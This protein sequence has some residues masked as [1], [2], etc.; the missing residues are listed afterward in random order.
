MKIEFVNP[1]KKNLKFTQKKTVNK[2]RKAM[3]HGLAFLVTAFI[4][5]IV[6]YITLPAYNLHSFGFLLF[7]A[8]SLALWATLDQI[9]T[10]SIGKYHKLVYIFSGLIV[11]F[12]AIFS[13][14]SA[15]FLNARAYRDQ[16]V[17]SEISSFKDGFEAVDLN[18]V[19]VLDKE[20]AIQLG[21]KQ[22]GMVASLGSQYFVHDDYTL[23]A[24]KDSIYRISALDYRDAIK[25][26]N[27][28]KTGITSF[29]S[30]NVTNPNDVRLVDYPQG[31]RYTPHAHL[32]DNLMRKVRFNHR[33]AIIGGYE[34]EV[35]DDFNPFWVFSVVKPEIGWFGGHSA[36]GVIILNPSTG[37]SDYYDLDEVPAWVDRVQ[38]TEIAWSQIDNWGYYVNGFINTLF[39]QKE[40]LQTTEGYNYVLLNGNIYVFSGITSIGADNSIVGFALINLKTK[41]AIFYQVGG[42]DEYSAMSSA[43][44]QVQHLNYKATFPVLLNIGNVPSYFMSLKD[45]EGLVKKYAFVSVSNYDA[46]G[47]GDS[48]GAALNDYGLRLIDF[49]IIIEDAKLMDTITGTVASINTIVDQ[50][51]TIYYI[52]LNE[53]PRLFKVMAKDNIE[54][55][56]ATLDDEVEITFYDSEQ[57]VVEAIQFDHLGVN[58]NP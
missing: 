12:A 31:M 49:D 28:R 3:G 16:I 18:K 15:E 32:N 6:D 58:F 38:P 25:W 2:K 24:Q 8:L 34:L 53:S 7:I 30:V 33:W 22:I 54:V 45:N 10:F 43:Q 52:T 48:I 23:L 51:E 42:A 9:F 19:P 47:V 27:N 40:M 17:I 56:F 21:E 37:E 5:F 14:L 1:F 50:G 44:G 11:A 41:E 57:L 36:K 35:D 26:F 20:T 55:I 39:A 4:F 46:V 13:L 29:V